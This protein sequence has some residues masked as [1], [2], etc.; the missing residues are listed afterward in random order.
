MVGPTRINFTIRLLLI[1]IVFH[2]KNIEIVKL[3][4]LLKNYNL[5]VLKRDQLYDSVGF[6]NM[7]HG[8]GAGANRK[9]DAPLCFAMIAQRMSRG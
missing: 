8:I 3:G 7:S 1:C 2:T 9:V 5:N 6:G 4:P